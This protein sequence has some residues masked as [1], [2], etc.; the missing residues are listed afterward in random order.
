MHFDSRVGALRRGFAVADLIPSFLGLLSFAVLVPFF[1]LDYDTHHDGYLLAGAI[2]ASEGLVAHTQFHAQYGPLLPWT[3]SLFLLFPFSEV[4]NLRLWGASAISLTVFLIA[5]LHR[6]M[7]E[8]FSSRPHLFWGAGLTWL[9][10]ADFFVL[11][12]PLAWSSLLGSLLLAGS[13]FFLLMS[14]K[15][16]DLGRSSARYFAFFSGITAGLIVYSRINVGLAL[17]VG[18]ILL[19]IIDIK[20]RLATARIK[21]YFIIGSVSSLLLTALIL[22]IQGSLVEYLSQSVFGPAKWAAGAVGE[23]DWNTLS[24]LAQILGMTI[25]ALLLIVGVLL[26][27]WVLSSTENS[28]GRIAKSSANLMFFAGAA[29]LVVVLYAGLPHIPQLLAARTLAEV[30]A[31]LVAIVLSS[32]NILHVIFFLGLGLCFFMVFREMFVSSSKLDPLKKTVAVVVATYALAGSV[33]IVPT[34]D[35]RH[36]WWGLV[37]F[38][39][40]IIVTITLVPGLLRTFAPISLAIGVIHVLLLSLGATANLTFPRFEGP[41]DSIVEGINLRL[42]DLKGFEASSLVQIG[43]S[44][45]KKVV[46]ITWNGGDSVVTGKYLSDNKNFVWWADPNRD[47]GQEILRSDFVFTQ[48]YALEQIGYLTPRAFQEAYG[49]TVVE[50]VDNLCLYSTPR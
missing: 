3:Q 45:E 6:A 42:D 34:Y 39:V 46:F 29:G 44:S 16:A 28:L 37:L 49:L 31:V 48:E 12:Y 13:L 17:L 25:P 8:P 36:F 4:M 14:L 27:T 15:K 41:E 47:L 23:D 7:P 2:G 50:C 24:G 5:S 21:Q 43:L 22:H 26:R 9:L 19:I 20:F 1:I 11:G 18:V 10:T 32:P 40:L 30:R 33:Q 35:Y 38:P